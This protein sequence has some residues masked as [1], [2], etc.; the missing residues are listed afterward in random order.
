MTV[1]L[2]QNIKMFFVITA[3]VLI[4]TCALGAG[5]S[6]SAAQSKSSKFTQ[7]INPMYCDGVP[8]CDLQPPIINGVNNNSHHLR[9]YG[10]YDSLNSQSLRV[11]FNGRW[12][13]LGV[14]SQLTVQGNYWKL[15][16]G[17]DDGLPLEPGNYTIEV[18]MVTLMG[19]TLTY[20]AQLNVSAP[21]DNGNNSKPDE[22]PSVTLL[23]PSTGFW[24]TPEQYNK[25]VRQSLFDNIVIASG[26]CAFGLCLLLLAWRVNKR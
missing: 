17:D 5:G 8:D 6:V 19:Q 16:L 14:D 22:K 7:K 25:G 10:K 20:T 24:Y 12:Y 18:S 9:V 4:A 2:S 26:V 11:L 23:P 1:W 21:A 13:T 3:V 15:T